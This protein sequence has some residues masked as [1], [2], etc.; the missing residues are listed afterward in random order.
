MKINKIISIAAFAAGVLGLALAGPLPPAQDSGKY[1]V[2]EKDKI[3]QIL[4]FKDPAATRREVKLD[5]VF[6][7]IDVQGTDGSDVELSAQ[8]TIRARSREK[9]QQAKD[10]VKLDIRTDGGTIDIYVDGPFRCRTQDCTGIKD[11]DWGYEVHYDFVLKVPR[12]AALTLKTVTG[13]D[14]TV[15]GVE[16]DFLVT[17]VNGKIG[18]DGVVGS[19]EARTVNGP[20]R[21]GFSRNPK[22]AC[23]FKTINGDVELTFRDG[24]AADLK[25]KTFNGEAFS[26]FEV[27]SLPLQ[28]EAPVTKNGRF[29]YKRN[30]FSRLRIGGGG[31]EITCDTLNGDIL[32]KK[33][34]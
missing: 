22:A 4:K 2:E 8:K 10:E 32:I 16:G 19:G 13:G 27:K 5:N 7:A 33:S 23:S 11:R 3:E 9:V 28:A 20:V 1:P 30:G 31:P 18:L 6:G 29:T 12:K 21:V 26:D 25:V 15:R 17:N 24:L 34:H 14:I